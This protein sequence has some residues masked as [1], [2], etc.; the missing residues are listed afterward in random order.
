[1]SEHTMPLYKK[2]NTHIKKLW[3]ILRFPMWKNDTPK[4]N[5]VSNCHENSTLKSAMLIIKDL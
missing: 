2:T 4:A 1:M 5:S 3:N